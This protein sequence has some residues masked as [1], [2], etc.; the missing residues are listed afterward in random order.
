VNEHDVFH[1]RGFEFR[2]NDD[3]FDYWESGRWSVVRERGGRSML[4][5]ATWRYSPEKWESAFD[6][7]RP[8]DRLAALDALIPALLQRTVR[9]APDILELERK[10]V[11][12]RQE[13]S[14][15]LS[16]IEKAKLVG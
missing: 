7:Q 6:P 10:I 4:W 14:E 8:W 2:P 16:D 12:L 11:F 5:R 3:S 13:H 9:Y 1:W 15:L